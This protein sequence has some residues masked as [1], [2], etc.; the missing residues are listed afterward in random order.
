[1]EFSTLEPGQYKGFHERS[2]FNAAQIVCAIMAAIVLLGLYH[3]CFE[4]GDQDP[5]VMRSKV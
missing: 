1:V 3:P 5:P 2:K 4:A